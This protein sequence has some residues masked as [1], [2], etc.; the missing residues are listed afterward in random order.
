METAGVYKSET[1]GLVQIVKELDVGQPSGYK[2]I[3]G[4]IEAGLA[5][6]LTIVTT[7]PSSRTWLAVRLLN[8]LSRRTIVVVV[9]DIAM[10]WRIFE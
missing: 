8:L 2:P 9:I 3:M 5:Q 1:A 6:L 4:R 10:R 7:R